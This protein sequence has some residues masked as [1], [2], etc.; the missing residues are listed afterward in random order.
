MSLQSGIDRRVGGSPRTLTPR[1]A[2]FVKEVIRTL[3]PPQSPVT[4]ARS[5]EAPIKSKVEEKQSEKQT[6]LFLQSLAATTTKTKRFSESENIDVLHI[7]PKLA[8]KILSSPLDKTSN[9]TLTEEQTKTKETQPASSTH[10]KNPGGQD[11][12]TDIDDNKMLEER[13]KNILR[14]VIVSYLIGTACFALMCKR[15]FFEPMED[16]TVHSVI[17]PNVPIAGGEIEMDIT[18]PAASTEKSYNTKAKPRIG[19]GFFH[20]IK[21]LGDIEDFL[22]SLPMAAKKLLNE[23]K[24][25]H[26][27]LEDIDT[28]LLI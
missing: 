16:V 5:S 12:Q 14:F 24:Q 6:H 26:Y 28:C 11:L 21:L 10:L 8:N 9:L 27:E 2:V 4:V 15:A 13:F 18:A 1:K 25:L 22:S 17:T 23:S 3:S 19:I 7:P 20:E